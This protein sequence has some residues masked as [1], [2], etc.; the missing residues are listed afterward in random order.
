MYLLLCKN[1][2]KRRRFSDF[3]NAHKETCFQSFLIML[4]T[5]DFSIQT[6]KL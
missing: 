1:N 4:Q 3:G 2:K 5:R 6:A